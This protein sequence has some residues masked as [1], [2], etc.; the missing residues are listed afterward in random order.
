ML[1]LLTCILLT[2][3]PSGAFSQAEIK[4]I[5]YSDLPRGARDV[6]DG[7]KTGSVNWPFKKHDGKVFGNREKLLPYGG[8][9]SYREYT[10]CTPKMNKQLSEGKVP[11]RGTER[12]IYDVNNNIYYYTDDHYKTFRRVEFRHGESW[13]SGKDNSREPCAAYICIY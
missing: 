11:N 13:Q 1:Y 6:I 3:F 5:F 8:N 10:V 9:Q 2:G 12:I 4:T 7:I